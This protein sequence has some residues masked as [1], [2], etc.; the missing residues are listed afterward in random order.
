MA[1]EHVLIPKTK[2]EQ[3]TK[4]SNRMDDASTQ[5]EQHFPDERPT[6]AF[7]QQQNTNDFPMSDDDFN[8]DASS[9]DNPDY[10]SYDI[11]TSA[12]LRV[13]IYPHK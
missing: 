1:T 12:I 3:L 4:G 7:Q 5:T 8:S 11:V 9:E 2:Y 13:R 6:D 10:D